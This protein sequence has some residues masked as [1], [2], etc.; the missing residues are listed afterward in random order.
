MLKPSC[1]VGERVRV[2]ESVGASVGVRLMVIVDDGE[3]GGIGVFVGKIVSVC[4]GCR[5]VIEMGCSTPRL[6]GISCK[7]DN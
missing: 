4:E 3:A 2:G 7:G 1:N 6:D 5:V